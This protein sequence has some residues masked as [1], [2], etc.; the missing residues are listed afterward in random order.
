MP[1]LSRPKHELFAQAMAGGK[2][3]D[4]AYVLAGY[5][6][7]RGNASRL[8][9]NDSIQTRVREL[10]ERASANVVLSREWVLEQLVDNATKAKERGDGSVANRALELLG[11]HL[12]MFKDQVEHSGRMTLEALVMA[13]MR[14][15]EENQT[16]TPPLGPELSAP[17]ST[18]Y[19]SGPR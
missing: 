9:A 19:L 5:K 4:E 8:T 16:G 2:T 18:R 1:V 17:D 10:Q 14:P 7:D 12:R 3:A 13:S 15:P 6:S 11:K